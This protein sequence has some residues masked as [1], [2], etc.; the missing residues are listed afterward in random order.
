MSGYGESVQ[1]GA[2][3]L[4]HPFT[5]LSKPFDLQRLESA[6]KEA[7]GLEENV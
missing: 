3:T 1:T 7:V 6:V 2:G 4:K 5:V